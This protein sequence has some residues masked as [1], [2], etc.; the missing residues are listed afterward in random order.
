M[1]VNELFMKAVLKDCH[2][3]KNLTNQKLYQILNA[4]EM[5]KMNMKVNIC[6]GV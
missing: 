4:Y 2:I 6:R 3:L 1:F 5:T